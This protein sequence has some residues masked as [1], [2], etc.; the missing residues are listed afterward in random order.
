M[1][2]RLRS[3]SLP[4]L[5]ALIS[6]LGWSGSASAHFVLTSPEAA[7]EQNDLGNPQ[8]APPCGDDGSAVA[9]GEVTSYQPGETI[10]IEIDETI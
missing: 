1:S 9:T 5:V 8:K 7:T 3:S 2:T 4:G 6:A 10:T